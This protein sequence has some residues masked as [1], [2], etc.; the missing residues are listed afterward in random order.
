MLGTVLAATIAAVLGVAL[1][2]GGTLAMTH[3]K[4]DAPAVEAAADVA[5]ATAGAAEA[6][7]APAVEEQQTVQAVI[8][9]DPA[10]W[11]CEGDLADPLG[12]AWAV[13][14]TVTAAAPAGVQGAPTCA[15]LADAYIAGQ[16][17]PA[18]GEA[19]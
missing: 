14:V 16:Q 19:P 1:G 17:R 18:G 8:A 5:E 11:L 12:C 3:R 9:A 10:H 6:A 4:S 13:C 15:D 2:A 7:A